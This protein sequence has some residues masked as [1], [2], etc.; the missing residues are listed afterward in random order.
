MSQTIRNKYNKVA[1]SE[2]D[3]ITGI[4][5][6]QDW[7]IREIY[8][9]Q[10][11]VIKK[12]VYTFRNTTLEPNDIFQEGLTRAILNIRKG[13]FNQHSTFSTYLNGICKN[14]CL[15]QLHQK[16]NIS[17]IKK[18]TPEFQEEDLYY[19]MLSLINRIK[20]HLNTNCRE[21]IDL[22]FNQDDKQTDKLNPK[23]KL[24]GFEEIAE[25]LN[26]TTDNARQR[27]KRCLKQLRKMVFEH[28]EYKTLFD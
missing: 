12:M 8:K 27:F 13:K 7:A 25:R 21:I 15:K 11:V 20:A 2:K 28:P 26:I 4:I 16:K 24:T 19:E 1:Y 22:R 10:Y 23:N 9:T 17:V 18:Q 3:L 14:I 6:N 5:Q